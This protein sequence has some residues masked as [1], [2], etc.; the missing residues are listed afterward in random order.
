[1]G[2]DIIHKAAGIIIRDKKLL[3]ERS[4]GRKF[5]I[6]PGGSIEQGETSEQALVREL[7]EE[8]QINVTEE[9][10]KKFG[11]FE[12][13]AAEQE[14]KTVVMEVFIVERWEGEPHPDSEVEEIAWV[15]SSSK[16]LLGSIFEHEVMPRL[17]SAQLIG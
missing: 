1:M 8:F 3:V 12:A 15:D 6:S 2:S 11:T 17:K 14:N 9:N 5:F 13:A 10:I 4:K 7:K 16:I